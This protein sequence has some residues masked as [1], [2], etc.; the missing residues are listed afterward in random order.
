M[1]LMIAY[2]P[3]SQWKRANIDFTITYLIA[4]IGE[5]GFITRL[6]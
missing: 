5:K 3:S 2:E 6:V 4:T 1:F